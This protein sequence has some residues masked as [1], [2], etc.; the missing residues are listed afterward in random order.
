MTKLCDDEGCP[1]FGTDHYCIDVS[2]L[3]RRECVAVPAD[4]C[5][6]RAWDAL[7]LDESELAP[8]LPYAGHAECLASQ[9][10]EF[11]RHFDPEPE[12]FF[13]YWGG[14]AAFWW[15]VLGLVA[16]IAIMLTL[17]ALPVVVTP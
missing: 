17:L 6:P 12:P 10:K 9:G 3:N 1:H 14:P 16:L 5:H 13:H 7:R 4:L 15:D 11:G 8:C 2:R